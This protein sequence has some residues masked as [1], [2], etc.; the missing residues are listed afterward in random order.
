MQRRCGNAHTLL[1]GA[2]RP[3]G[4]GPPAQV[5]NMTITTALNKVQPMHAPRSGMDGKAPTTAQA[6]ARMGNPERRAHRVGNTA[7]QDR[8]QVA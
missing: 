3:H 8:Q 5:A 4:R 7:E 1:L 2:P 6:M